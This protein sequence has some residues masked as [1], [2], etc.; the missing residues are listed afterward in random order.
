MGY[1]CR[2]SVTSINLDKK[3]K[4]AKKTFT[5]KA[6]T[7]FD[8]AKNGFADQTGKFNILRDEKTNE[9]KGINEYE[10]MIYTDQFF[11]HLKMA[12]EEDA[13]FEFDD[14]NNLISIKVC[15]HNA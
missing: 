8:I 2:G 1:K 6:K 7:Q 4:K 11:A 15:H 14:K 12:Y 10:E 9:F 13:I 3:S 5:C